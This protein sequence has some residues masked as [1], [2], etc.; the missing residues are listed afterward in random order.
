MNKIISD[1]L[2]SNL[3]EQNLVDLLWNTT[4][5][6][7]TPR[8]GWTGYMQNI[9][10]SDEQT[11]V[12]ST[13]FLPMTDINPATHSCVYMTLKFICS[14]AE[15][16]NIA[17]PVVTFDRCLWIKA[18]EVVCNKPEEFPNILIHLGGFHALMSYLGTIGQLLCGS[19]IEETLK[20]VLHML[21]GKA[22]SRAIT[23]HIVYE[24]PIEPMDTD[25]IQP[26]LPNLQ[27][28][29]ELYNKLYNGEI[30]VSEISSSTE[31][32]KLSFELQ[33]KKNSLKRQSRTEK[34][35]IMYLDMVDIAK[36]FIWAE[37]TGNLKMHLQAIKHV[38]PF[39]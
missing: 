18:M 8:P 27:S 33:K 37:R 35:C 23:G 9:V 22:Y 34:L 6:L 11:G 28:L 24:E 7:K 38:L 3:M 39:L 2:F 36:V 30:A 19:G 12:L 1:E 4:K 20:T 31:L 25:E 26:S 5:L 21:T 15:K 16:L 14:E 29:M 10:I 17:L 32:L 13:T